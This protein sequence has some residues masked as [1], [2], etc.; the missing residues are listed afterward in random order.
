MERG[1]DNT[2]IWNDEEAVTYILSSIEN[3]LNPQDGPVCL[4]VCTSTVTGHLVSAEHN[5]EIAVTGFL[6][7]AI[8]FCKGG[9]HFST[10]VLTNS[11]ASFTGHQSSRAS[12]C[13]SWMEWRGLPQTIS[14]W[15]PTVS[16]ASSATIHHLNND[17]CWEGW[18]SVALV[19]GKVRCLPHLILAVVEAATWWWS[20][21]LSAIVW[22]LH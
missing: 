8:A 20:Y 5:G 9:W 15:G 16:R 22:W 18:K 3:M 13:R 17:Y 1:L 19:K 4:G 2:W 7:Q 21:R 10:S 12:E 14:I 6:D 11:E